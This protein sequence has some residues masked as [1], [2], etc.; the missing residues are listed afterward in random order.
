MKK[1]LLLCIILC[2]SLSEFPVWAQKKNNRP[3]DV[4][5]LLG[6]GNG[7]DE[8]IG[9][10]YETQLQ[11]FQDPR[12][13]RFLLLDQKRKVALGI[14]GYVKLTVSDDFKGISDNIDFIPYDIAVPNN[15]VDNG[16]FQMDVFTSRLFLKLVGAN[17]TLG[18]YTAYIETDFRGPH[19]TLRLRQAYV[20]MKGFLLGQSW[21]TFSDLSALPPTI[22][23]QGPNGNTALRNVQL[24]YTFS[25]GKHWSAAAAI[26]APQVS[27]TLTDNTQMIH[28][29]MPDIPLWIQFDWG[30]NSHIRASGLFRGLSYRND[31]LRKNRMKMGWGVQMSGLAEIIPQL[32]FYY[33]GTYGK[34]ISQY[35]TDLSGNNLDLVPDPKN[36]GHLQAVPV[37]AVVGGIRWNIT[38]KLFTSANYSL[39]HVYYENGYTVSDGYK[40]G[41]YICG[42]MF[43][44]LTSSC[45]LGVEY[46]H[47]IREDKNKTLGH[48]NRVQASVQYNF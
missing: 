33:Q 9:I 34:G 10:F 39:A 36:P 32:S 19:H 18:K 2:L 42:N 47:G 14:G 48:A 38:P 20:S 43:Y 21:S 44:N 35:V 6:K 37:L 25:L 28:Q 8:I 40:Q 12:A 1:L 46:L 31:I 5:F 13:P 29:R 26:E 24:R 23:F 45:M 30:K 16:Q 41:Q 3:R 22:D 4:I 15:H 17:K 27:Y 11:H 7:N